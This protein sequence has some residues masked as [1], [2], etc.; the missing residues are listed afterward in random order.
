MSITEK[1]FKRRKQ[2]FT[3]SAV[4]LAAFLKF[5]RSKTKRKKK[6][7]WFQEGFK[8]WNAKRKLKYDNETEENE[9]PTKRMTRSLEVCNFFSKLLTFSC[10]YCPINYRPPVNLLYEFQPGQNAAKR[11]EKGPKGSRTM[12]I[13]TLTEG[14]KH[15]SFCH[16]GKYIFLL[17]FSNVTITYTYVHIMY[18]YLKCFLKGSQYSKRIN[19]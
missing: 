1:R 2:V 4:L 8:N 15:C 3:T 7:K 6:L 19:L 12:D 11:E 10:V 5:V 18:L 9:P 16:R 14:L 17:L 13:E